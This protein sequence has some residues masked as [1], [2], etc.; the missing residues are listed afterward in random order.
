MRERGEV[1][2]SH[3]QK[4]SS[5][6]LHAFLLV[7][8][9]VM[10]TNLLYCVHGCFAALCVLARLQQKADQESK[11]DCT[12]GAQVNICILC[13]CLLSKY[14]GRQ[15]DSKRDGEEKH[16]VINNKEDTQQRK[17]RNQK[18]PWT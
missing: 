13:T 9:R 14:E 4:T 11:Q 17:G 6:W 10:D 1:N 16:F 18:E 5:L 2:E 7:L 15:S 8:Q 12:Q 3:G